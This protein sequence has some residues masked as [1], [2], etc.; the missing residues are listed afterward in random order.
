MITE[1][2]NLKKRKS[3]PEVLAVAD[4]TLLTIDTVNTFTSQDGNGFLYLTDRQSGIYLGL[5]SIFLFFV[6]FWV[7]I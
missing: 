7:W 2:I 6:S 4:I 5:P 1:Q 3:I